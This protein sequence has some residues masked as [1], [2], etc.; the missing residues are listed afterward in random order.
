MMVKGSHLAREEEKG[1]G[2][3]LQWIKS[4]Q[5]VADERANSQFQSSRG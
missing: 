5:K 4:G 2:D 3:G 1:E